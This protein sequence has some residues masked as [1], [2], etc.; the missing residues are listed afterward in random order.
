MIAYLVNQ[1]KIGALT[2]QQV[3]TSQTLLEK[4]PTLKEDLDKYITEKGINIDTSML[5]K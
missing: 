5:I 2:Y 4:R 3:I 1:F